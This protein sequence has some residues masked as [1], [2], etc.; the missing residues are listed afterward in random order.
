MN[1]LT[2]GLGFG[3]QNIIL[4]GYSSGEAVVVIPTTTNVNG[5]LP[6][7]T[8]PP[9]IT[10]NYTFYIGRLVVRGKEECYAGDNSETSTKV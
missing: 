4:R 2:K 5:L 10:Y 3:A 9:N 1:I 7:Y 8:Y 6:T